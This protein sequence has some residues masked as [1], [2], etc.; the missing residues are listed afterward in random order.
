M[1]ELKW[2]F[3]DKANIKEPIEALKQDGWQYGDIPT[4]SNFNWLFKE[5]TQA[6]LATKK[7]IVTLRKAIYDLEKDTRTYTH[8][9]FSLN[10]LSIN[11]IC[12][13]LYHLEDEH[14]RLNHGMSFW[15][16][17]WNYNPNY[18]PKDRKED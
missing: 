8:E 11:Q 18:K 10:E 3:G 6:L 15:T 12:Q 4:A 17:P 13:Y 7:E 16:L 14:R 9:K 1:S 5:L 2:G